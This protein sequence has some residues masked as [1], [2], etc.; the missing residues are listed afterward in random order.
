MVPAAMS[1]PYMPLYVGDYLADTTHL[2]TMEHGAYLLI[3]MALWRNGGELPNDPN[4]I[5]KCAKL[6]M[7]KWRR[8]EST[9]MEFFAVDGDRIIHARVTKE[10]QHVTEIRTSRS[11]AGRRG[12]EA[13]ALKKQQ[14]DTANVIR[15]HTQLEPE[16]DIRTEAKASVGNRGFRLPRTWSPDDDLRRWATDAGWTEKAILDETESFRD[17]WCEIAGA[18]GVKLDWRGAW[19]NWLKRSDRRPKNGTSPKL[20]AKQENLERAFRAGQSLPAGPRQ[21]F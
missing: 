11:D 15:L 3:I 19:R 8:I 18:K 16:L 4:R 7:D 13:K 6:T 1:P 9:I 5:A 20:T 2:S 10:L 17:Y 14:A 21:L 12:N